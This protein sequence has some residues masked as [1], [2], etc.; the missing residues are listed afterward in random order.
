MIAHFCNVSKKFFVVD[1]VTEQLTW[2]AAWFK[3]F[4]LTVCIDWLVQALWETP[5]I[6]LMYVLYV[7]AD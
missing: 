5:V 3:P 6:I 4:S 1:N 2:H 7:V